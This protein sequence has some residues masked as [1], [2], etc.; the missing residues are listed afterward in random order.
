MISIYPRMLYPQGDAT[1]EPVIVFDEDQ[2]AACRK[3]GYL[4]L[5]DKP[6]AEKGGSKKPA[7]KGA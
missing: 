6:P 1:A 2:E 7:E 4:R 3:D 5:G